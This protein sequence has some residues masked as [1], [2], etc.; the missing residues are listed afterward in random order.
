MCIAIAFVALALPLAAVVAGD[1]V[2]LHAQAPAGNSPVPQ[3]RELYTA[4]C[5]ACHEEAGKGRP[6]RFPA[7]Q[8]NANLRDLARFVGIVRRGQ[9]GMPPFPQ[10]DAEQ[11]AA[12]AAYVRTAWENDFGLVTREQVEALLRDTE[13]VPAAG[14]DRAAWYTDEQAARGEA[15]YLKRCAECHGA[16][17]VPDDF[18]TGLTGA[19]FDWQ[20]KGRTVYDLFETIRTTMPPAE[21]GTLGPRATADIVAYLLKA[22]KFPAGVTELD[23]APETMQK[24]RIER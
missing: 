11:I 20:W 13:A 4:R 19:A 3:G 10:L 6:P 22:N 21:E 7:L 14:A 5:A 1:A 16:D 23:T 8:G 9:G 2:P 17:F 12:L 24:M 15:L 18:A